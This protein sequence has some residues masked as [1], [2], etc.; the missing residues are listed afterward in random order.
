MTMSTDGPGEGPR[1]ASISF[2]F[3]SG[4][5][6]A[7]SRVGERHEPEWP[8]HFGRAYM[9]MVAALYRWSRPQHDPDFVAEREALLALERLSPPG[10]HAPPAT[11]IGLPVQPVS[12]WEANRPVSVYV[13]RNHVK[14]MGGPGADRLLPWSQKG[15]VARYFPGMLLQPSP[16][17]AAELFDPLPEVHFIWTGEAAEQIIRVSEPLTR[18][19]QFVTYLGTSRS[20]VFADISLDPPAPN[21]RP[22]T[23]QER[24]S[25]SDI[26]VRVPGEGRLRLLE[27]HFNRRKR[28]EV[29]PVGDV[30]RYRRI[31]TRVTGQP[32]RSA[33]SS[34][35]DQF[36]FRLEGRDWLHLSKALPVTHG[37][38]ETVLSLAG[39]RGR[40]AVVSGHSEDPDSVP[41]HLAWVPLANVGYEHSNGR[42]LGIAAVLPRSLDP[43][44]SGR[45]QALAA[46]AA[47]RGPSEQG[48]LSLRLGDLG[49]PRIRP[50]TGTPNLS[51][52]DTRR[53]GRTAR[54]WA[55]VTP[56]VSELL[57]IRDNHDARRLVRRACRTVGLP[58]PL[59]CTLTRISPLRGVPPADHFI[60]KRKPSDPDCR[61]QHVIIDFGR[62]VRGPI[63]IG[64]YR[65]FGMGLCLPW[66][67][68]KQD[69]NA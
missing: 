59:D 24:A 60:A 46:L 26:P 66:G 65:Y 54:V 63:L 31:E 52:L 49:C 20:L 35:G 11:L 27:E 8:P 9:A 2:T 39:D 15:K 69:F 16:P 1:Q 62:P 13:R 19:L 34:F 51:S 10:I 21:Y 23:P 58:D 36:V 57:G 48:T 45:R 44:T 32:P 53:Y 33:H 43:G 50:T 4:V 47:L 42:I 61:C 38:R 17:S 3:M 5:Y 56:F 18:L 22:L 6:Y 41:D 64:R 40:E 14:G 37:F 55:S 28:S 25:P 30:R 12:S 7:A 29:P 67:T 68:S